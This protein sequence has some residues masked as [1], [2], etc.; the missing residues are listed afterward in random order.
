[1]MNVVKFL[2]EAWKALRY[3]LP[4]GEDREGFK[5]LRE[6]AGIAE[7]IQKDWTPGQ[8]ALR[9]ENLQEQLGRAQRVQV[10]LDLP[11]V[12]LSHREVYP[13]LIYLLNHTREEKK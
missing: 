3:I 2:N 6:A 7:A 10:G 4:P 11:A 5:Q 8:A 13:G 9:L 12:F 1:M